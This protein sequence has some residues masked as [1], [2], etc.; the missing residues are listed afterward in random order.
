MPHSMTGFAR[1][2]TETPRFSL[3]LSLKSVN[4]RFLDVQM[5]LPAELEA[6]EMSARQAI[7]KRISRGALQLSA[8]LEQR[9]PVSVRIQRSLAEGY[10]AAYRDLA[11]DCGL[12]AEPDLNALLRLPGLVTVAGPDQDAAGELEQALLAAIERAIEQLCQ[13]RSREGAGIAEEIERRRQAIEAALG[14]VETLRE[15]LSRLLAERLAQKL[16]ELLKMAAVDPK[17]LLQ[18][19]ALL[20]ERSD[21][22]EELQRLRAHAGQ[23]RPL[24]DSPGQV[25]KRLDFLLQEMGREAN[26]LVAKTSGLGQTGLEI[27]D[28]GLAVK[29]EIEKIREQAMNLE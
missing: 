13:A 21:I 28:L 12:A 17:R 8:G 16:S 20:A 5:R 26:T 19:A 24:L 3:T 23:L 6:F 11:R 15:G 18:E 4:H 29:A 25:G 9:G 14:R 27:S 22:S 1:V 7:K 2:Q 10:V